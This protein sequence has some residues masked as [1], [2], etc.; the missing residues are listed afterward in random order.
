MSVSVLATAVSSTSVPPTS[1]KELANAWDSPTVYGSPSLTVAALEAPSFLNTLSAAAFPWRVSLWATRKYPGLWLSPG[2]VPSTVVRNGDVFD[3]EIMVKPSGERIP[4]AGTAAPEQLLPMIPTIW[5]F[6]A[7]IF[8]AASAPGP[9]VPHDWPP[10]SSIWT[11]SILWPRSVSPLSSMA[12]WAPRTWSVP[13]LAP[14]PVIASRIAILIGAPAATVTA[15][16]A[17]ALGGVAV[18]PPPPPHA[19]ARRTKTPSSAP[20]ANNLRLFMLPPPWGHSPSASTDC[21]GSLASFEG[22]PPAESAS[23]TTSPRE[24]PGQAA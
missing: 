9:E 11:R 18:V 12:I 17:P 15:P 10:A 16:S 1:L 24:T 13:R 7:A 8:W 21:G 6:W 22:L 14:S 5:S 2:V 3:P 23:L 20:P 4:M 19:E